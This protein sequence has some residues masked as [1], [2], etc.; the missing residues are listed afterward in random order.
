MAKVIDKTL[1]INVLSLLAYRGTSFIFPLVTLPY[2]AR[3]L[4]VEHMGL[5][6]LGLACVMYCSTISDWGF[7]VYTTKDI[8]QHRDDKLRVTQLFWSTFNA[9]LILG[10][11]T[12][13]VL[14]LVTW[15]NPAW[16]ALFYIVLANSTVL[17][18]QLLSFG[19]LMQGFEKLGK[20][21]II[22][23]IG[24]FCSIPLTF[25]LVKTPQDT[26]LA[27]LIPGVVAFITAIITMSLVVQMRVIGFYRFEP[28]EIMQRIKDSLHVFLAI[29]G[30]NMFNNINVL[31]LASMT[32]T[33]MVGLYNGADRLKKAANSVPEQIGNAFFPRVSHLFHKD[34]AA[35]IAASQKSISLSFL[36]SLFI[37]IFTFFFADFV[38]RILLGAAFHESANVLRVAVCGF[39]FGNISYPAGL[40]I[41][42]PH[43][44]A[45]QRMH[46]MFI[47][48]LI[49]I[50][51]CCLMAWK[52]GAIGAAGSLV[53]SEFL[54]FAG[55]LRIMVKH[56]ILKT[57][58]ARPAVFKQPGNE[59]A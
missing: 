22:S 52:F 49:N 6:A 40:Q 8:A 23:T 28:R 24:Q 43:G 30:A 21:S 41:L 59:Q 48:G 54:V 38:V 13:A 29:F 55:I 35:A 42:I 31:I 45:K 34:R 36:I 50:P 44:L 12:L 57:Y 14:L 18:G 32:S 3:I 2:L 10:C 7:N 56:D 5:L 27:A 20:T 33:Y 4:G 39:I 53:L 37:V 25:L 1:L 58:L 9:K 15:F 47:V 11:S 17:F 51:I 16:H 19:W 46:V 26:W